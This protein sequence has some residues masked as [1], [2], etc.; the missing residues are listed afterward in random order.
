MMDEMVEEEAKEEAAKNDFY[1]WIHSKTHK[2]LNIREKN[3][4]VGGKEHHHSP[5]VA[6][7]M[8]SPW[9]WL[10]RPTFS[11]SFRA[12]RCI[13]F[14]YGIFHAMPMLGHFWATFAI[15]FDL[16]GLKIT[17]IHMFW[18][19]KVEICKNTQNKQNYA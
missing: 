18:A 9:W 10:S 13:V 8:G 7:T 15:F 19:C 5:P 6:T 16:H 1:A 17:F 3:K 12:S 2:N 14:S 4:W 11:S